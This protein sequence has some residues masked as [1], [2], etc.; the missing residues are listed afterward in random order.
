MSRN[1]K[2]LVQCLGQTDSPAFKAWF[3][4]SKAVDQTGVPLVVYHGTGADFNSFNKTT[5]F[6]GVGFQFSDSQLF[7]KSYAGE[8]GRVIAAFLK[9]ERPY[10]VDVAVRAAFEDAEKT[11][12]ELSGGDYYPDTALDWFHE[13]GRSEIKQA[14]LTGKY[15]GYIIKEDSGSGIIGV[16]EPVQIKSAIG[17]CGDFSPENPDI[18]CSQAARGRAR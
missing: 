7:A 2:A 3:G 1:P 4:D 9:L 17:N 12:D 14:M 5:S 15:D 13:H 8:G 6:R 11:E 18:F 10:E 16:L